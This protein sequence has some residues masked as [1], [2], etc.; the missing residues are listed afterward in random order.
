MTAYWITSI[1]S[2]LRYYKHN[3]YAMHVEFTGVT[4][5]QDFLWQL[6]VALNHELFASAFNLLNFLPN[7]DPSTFFIS[8]D[9]FAENFLSGIIKTYDCWCFFLGSNTKKTLWRRD[10]ISDQA[11]YQITLIKFVLAYLIVRIAKKRGKLK[12]GAAIRKRIIDESCFDGAP[13][14]ENGRN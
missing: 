13:R 3:V 10:S 14:W 7:N 1:T 2:F 5:F 6:Y 11:E 12:R 4:L 8:L 9:F